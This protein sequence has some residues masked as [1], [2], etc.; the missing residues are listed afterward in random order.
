MGGWEGV[1][2]AGWYKIWVFLMFMSSPRR[3]WALA[4]AC[5]MLWSS[6]SER[7]TRALSSAYWS[8]MMGDV[9]TLLFA[10]NL[11]ML[12]SPPSDLY[13]SLAPSGRFGLVR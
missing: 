10:L 13:K 9:S 5:K 7:A 1:S 11:L 4:K 6:A 12:K 2:G 3:W 8:S